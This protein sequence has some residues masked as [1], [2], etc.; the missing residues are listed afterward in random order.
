MVCKGV[1]QRRWGHKRGP[2]L[3]TSALLPAFLLSFAVLA[4]MLIVSAACKEHAQQL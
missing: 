4:S 2:C 1:E 3:N